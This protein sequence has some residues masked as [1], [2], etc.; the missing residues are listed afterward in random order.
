[1]EEVKNWLGWSLSATLVAADGIDGVC[2][3]PQ[4]VIYHCIAS[5]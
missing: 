3:M 4:A 1:M 5:Q 2:G